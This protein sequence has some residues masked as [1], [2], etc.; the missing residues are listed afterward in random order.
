MFRLEG[1][2][3][4]RTGPAPRAD[5]PIPGMR[6][7]IIPAPDFSIVRRDGCADVSF[8][9]DFIVSSPVVVSRHLSSTLARLRQAQFD[10][11]QIL[12]RATG[13]AVWLDAPTCKADLH[14]QVAFK[15][16]IL[17]RLQYAAPVDHAFAG[18]LAVDI[19]AMHVIEML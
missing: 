8:P 18:R 11:L 4:A 17:Q 1:L 9:S 5:K 3:A 14:G 15:V 19:G 13:V 2:S 7:P 6:L 12:D 16:D 10:A